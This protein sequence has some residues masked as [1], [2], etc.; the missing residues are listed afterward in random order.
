M[1]YLLNL[2]SSVVNDSLDSQRERDEAYMAQAVDLY[3]L[4]RR[5]RDIDQ[6]GRH[7]W[8]PIAAGLYVR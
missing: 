6:R 2:L 7:N 4:E 8:S 5:I 3:D 1:K